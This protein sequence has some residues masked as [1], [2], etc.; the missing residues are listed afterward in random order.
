M[1]G[2]QNQANHY[3]GLPVIFMDSH[4]PRTTPASPPKAPPAMMCNPRLK[5]A[6][7]F[8]TLGQFCYIMPHTKAADLKRN[9]S[10][11]LDIMSSRM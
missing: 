4:A 5:C 11:T 7:Y 3:R 9:I 1:N 6:M 8:L 2:Q 10:A